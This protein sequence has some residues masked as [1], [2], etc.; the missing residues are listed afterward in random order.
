MRTD[1]LYSGAIENAALTQSEPLH[2]YRFSDNY[3]WQGKVAGSKVSIRSNIVSP[4]YV[5]TMQMKLISG[6]DFYPTPGVD[7]SN[8]IINESMAKL[9]GEAGKTGSIITRDSASWTVVGIVKDFVYNDMS[10][11]VMPL[12]LLCNNGFT[13]V[14]VIS[15][16]SGID[17]KTA[18]KKTESVFKNRN[19]GF[20]FEYFFVDDEDCGNTKLSNHQTLSHKYGAGTGFYF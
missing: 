16:K 20:P 6:R 4:E 7:T 5:S 8:V 1:L 3:N 9:M 15:L 12:I 14:M 2:V 18:I 19:P 17:I 13:E 11:S 10:S